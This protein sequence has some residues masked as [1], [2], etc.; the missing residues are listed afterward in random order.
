MFGLSKSEKELARDVVIDVVA[1]KVYGY[2]VDTSIGAII[3]TMYSESGTIIGSVMNG[4]EEWFV[5]TH[6]GSYNKD[7]S[8]NKQV[9]IIEYDAL[10][11]FNSPRHGKAEL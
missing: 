10:M 11:I 2:D 3:H 8:E 6:V 1:R 7:G 4:S 9:S 5:F